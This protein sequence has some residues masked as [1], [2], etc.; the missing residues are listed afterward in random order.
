MG[1][2]EFKWGYSHAKGYY[3]GYKLTIVVDKRNLKPLAFLIHEDSHN[4]TKL[5]RE[6]L[7]ELKCKRILRKGDVVLADKGYCS[8][9][10][11]VMAIP[12]FKVVSLIV[13][14]SAGD[15]PL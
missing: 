13:L 7:Q 15:F 12:R 1:D 8:Y 10:N 4:D 9:R 5:F 3:I 14:I 11:Y 6:I 2:K